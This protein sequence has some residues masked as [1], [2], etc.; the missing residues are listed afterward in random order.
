LKEKGEG[1]T[2]LFTPKILFAKKKSFLFLFFRVGHEGEVD[3]VLP[4]MILIR[5]SGDFLMNNCGH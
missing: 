5:F 4:D 1:A 2:I 3:F